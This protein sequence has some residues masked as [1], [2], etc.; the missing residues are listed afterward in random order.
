MLHVVLSCSSSTEAWLL[1]F[2]LEP[3]INLA[4]APTIFV[5]SPRF[6]VKVWRAVRLGP[7]G[8]PLSTEGYVLKRMFLEKGQ[9]VMQA[10][11]RYC[12]S[13]LYRK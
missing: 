10:G 7:D 6:A 2:G 8:E 13:L 3:S 9:H 12:T 11:I 5:C 4:R 1:R